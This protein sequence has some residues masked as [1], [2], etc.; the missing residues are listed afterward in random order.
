MVPT[1]KGSSKLLLRA[2]LYRLSC[3]WER[4]QRK[5]RPGEGTLPLPG[6]GRGVPPLDRF[7]QPQAVLQKR[8]PRGDL[9]HVSGVAGGGRGFSR[10]NGRLITVSD[11]D[12][13]RKATPR[14][15]GALAPLSLFPSELPWPEPGKGDSWCSPAVGRDTYVSD[16]VRV[17]SLAVSRF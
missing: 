10:E 4:L 14:P 17:C 15:C 8:R 11:V 12:C 9:G 1:R 2:I 6:S 7:P 3:H 5:P 16:P 13:S